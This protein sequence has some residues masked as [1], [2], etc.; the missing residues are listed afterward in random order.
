M[1]L[2]QQLGEWYPL[3][4]HVFATEWMQKLG[5]RIGACKTVQP[6]LHNLF[7]AFRLCPP[8]KVKVVIIGQDPYIRGEADGLAFSSFGR[9]TPSLEVIF[10][11][12]NR[13]HTCKRT[14][15]HLDDW[16]V[17]GVF[18]LNSVL[19]TEM[20]KSKAHADWGWEYFALDV[21]YQVLKLPQPIV[22]MTW[23]KDAQQ[24]WIDVQKICKLRK[25]VSHPNF[26]VLRT[27]HPQA[28][29]YNPANKFVGCNHFIEANLFLMKHGMAPIWW[30]DP[31]HITAVPSYF[32]YATMIQQLSK[33]I[34]DVKIDLSKI[35]HSYPAIP[36]Q[37]HPFDDGLESRHAKDLPF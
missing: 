4:S 34:P 32:P 6:Q 37:P 29:N 27:H 26:L 8:D 28:Q 16:A 35:V 15:T 1:N 18:L 10:E 3:L 20:G 33:Q 21:L 7:R 5:R 24:L 2:Q 9:S 14:Q 12:I 17:Q 30:S 36:D 31:D 19:T 25:Y 23:G 11:E 13:T 22:V